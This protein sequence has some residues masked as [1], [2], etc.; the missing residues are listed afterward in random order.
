MAV[1][2][3]DI[4]THVLPTRNPNQGFSVRSLYARK[5]ISITENEIKNNAWKCC[6]SLTFYSH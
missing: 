4:Y 6:V 5:K 1:I 2:S 3:H